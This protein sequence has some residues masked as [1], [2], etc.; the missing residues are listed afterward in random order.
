M[1]PNFHCL[2]PSELEGNALDLRV[3]PL[4]RPRLRVELLALLTDVF[5]L[6]TDVG[7]HLRRQL[8]QLDRAQGLDVLGFYRMHIEH[9]AIVQ[10]PA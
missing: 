8:G 3:A 4:D 10:A 7:Q 2:E 6:L 9:A 1:A 5:A